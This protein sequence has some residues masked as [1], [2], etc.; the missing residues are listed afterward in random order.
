MFWYTIHNLATCD[1]FDVHQVYND[2]T[3]NLLDEFSKYSGLGKYSDWEF[4]TNPDNW[5]I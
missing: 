4:F 5:E 1:E 3:E 2:L